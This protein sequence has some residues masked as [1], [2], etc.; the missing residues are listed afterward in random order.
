MVAIEEYLKLREK[1]EGFRVM[2]QKWRD[3]TFLHY[4]IEPEWL[5]GHVP[6]ELDIDTFPNANGEERAWVGLIPFWMTGVRARFFPP[7]PGLHQFAETNV[8]TYVHRNGK[9]PGVWFFSLDA[10][11]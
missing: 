3:L 10:A 8:R 2:Y 5:R 9:E 6:P 4:S 1:P 7:T 11:N